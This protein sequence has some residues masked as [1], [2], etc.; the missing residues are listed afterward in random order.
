MGLF[1]IST[2]AF[3]LDNFKEFKRDTWEFEAGT[4]YFYSE[5]NYPAAG[6]GSQSLT[7][8]NYFQNL[9]LNFASRYIPKSNWSVFG[10]GLVTN[11]ESKDSVATRSNSSFSEAALGF[12]F[13]MYDDYFQLIPEVIGILP[14]TEISPTSDTVANGEGVFEVRSRLIAQKD[15]GRYR[16]YGWLGFNYR[17]DGRSFLMP[18]GVGAQWRLVRLRLGAEVFGF[19]SIAD[20]SNT[21]NDAVRTSYINGVNAGSFRYF[22]KDP[23]IV[24]SQLYA[25]W[26]IT[27]KWSVQANGG[28]TFAGGNSAAGFHVGGFIRYVFDLTDGYSQQPRYEEPIESEVPKYRS[29]MYDDNSSN[30]QEVKSFRESTDDG[31]DQNLFRKKQPVKKTPPKVNRKRLQQQLDETEFK[32]QLKQDK[33]KKKRSY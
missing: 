16:T 26:L 10:W 7:S 19:Q 24:D 27:R 30:Q 18:W 9:D 13:V 22:T 2:P 21:T 11:A 12:D 17:A 31:V 8:G 33:K 4:Q 23:W 29:R 28:M 3:A 5:A 14:L 32:I 6:G 15:F 1:L 25:T 20:D